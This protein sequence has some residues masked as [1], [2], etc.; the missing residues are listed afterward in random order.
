M[1]H[2]INSFCAVR[3][4]WKLTVGLMFC[5]VQTALAAKRADV[6]YPASFGWIESLTT[7]APP[8]LITSDDKSDSKSAP[9]VEEVDVHDDL[10]RE[11]NL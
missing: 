2:A 10:K 5:S 6:E 8:L 4:G 11:A 3:I 7:D 1:E 9:T